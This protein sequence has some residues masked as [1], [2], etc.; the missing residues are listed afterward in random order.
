MDPLKSGAIFKVKNVGILR[1]RPASNNSSVKGGGSGDKSSS[2][3]SSSRRGDSESDR[4]PEGGR[5]PAKEGSGA[6]LSSRESETES[7]IRER[8]DHIYR[9]TPVP[10]AVMKGNGSPAVSGMI[11]PKAGAYAMPIPVPMPMGGPGPGPMDGYHR[12]GMVRMSP[13]ATNMPYN[14]RASPGYMHSRNGQRPHMPYGGPMEGS[15]PRPVGSPRFMGPPGD[16]RGG[17]F[18]VPQGMPGEMRVNKQQQQQQSSYDYSENRSPGGDVDY[19]Q[20]SSSSPIS[21]VRSPTGGSGGSTG[22]RKR[23]SAGRGRGVTGDSLMFLDQLPKSPPK[24]PV[25]EGKASSSF[26]S[27]SSLSRDSEEKRGRDSGKKR[28]RDRSMSADKG[29]KEEAVRV[30]A[31][32]QA[33]KKKSKYV[34]TGRPRGR[35]RKYP[36]EGGEAPKPKLPKPKPKPKPAPTP[37]SEE[38]DDD[39]PGLSAEEEE[40]DEDGEGGGPEM[41]QEEEGE[42]TG[43]EDGRRSSSGRAVNV[44]VTSIDLPKDDSP[45]PAAAGGRNMKF[46]SLSQTKDF[47]SAALAS[48]RADFI[49]TEEKKKKRGPKKQVEEDAAKKKIN[50]NSANALVDSDWQAVEV[51]NLYAA[52]KEVDPK[53]SD[54]WGKVAAVMKDKGCKRSS[55]DCSDKWN[56]SSDA[57]AKLRSKKKAKMAKNKGGKAAG[58]GAETVKSKTTSSGTPENQGDGVRSSPRLRSP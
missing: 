32:T 23:G 6:V 44:P 53:A 48:E 41:D 20:P 50:F 35:P 47:N 57:A 29:S 9:A 3:S 17:A 1:Q 52:Y 51:V 8:F 18:P 36:I 28:G 10:K 21:A 58:A 49:L 19:S 27:T 37:A 14:A 15:A 26:S 40:E 38:G 43:P 4:G 12:Q 2:S 11:M 7:L 22:S 34:P 5:S 39:T 42:G 56:K 33:K 54:F 13:S 46:L 31:A 25:S 16:G 24:P 30:S 55:K 45:A